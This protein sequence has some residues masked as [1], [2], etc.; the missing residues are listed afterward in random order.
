MKVETTELAEVRLITP[1]VFEDHRGV[2]VE[3][4]HREK[5]RAH[6]I[7][8]EFV[9]DDY[10]VSSRHVLRGIHAD[11]KAWKLVSCPYGRF[12]LAIVNC[13]PASGAFGRHVS[14]TLSESDRRQVLVP[15]LHGVAHLAL[16]DR[17]VFHYKQSEYYDPSRQTAYRWDDPRFA[18]PWPC[19]RPILSRRDG[20][21]EGPPSVA[22]P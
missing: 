21:A 10:S 15:P 2:Y 14:F 3:A 7:D 11:R 22:A 1:V 6:G 12:F 9:E 4:Y 18:I 13:D 20:G 5:F 19:R 8:L 17:V 16:S